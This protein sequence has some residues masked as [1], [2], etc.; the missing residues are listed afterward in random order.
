V[1]AEVLYD[2]RRPRGRRGRGRSWLMGNTVAGCS[3]E[4]DGFPLP[5]ERLHAQ[6]VSLWSLPRRLPRTT[7]TLGRDACTSRTH[8]LIPGW[9]VHHGTT[10]HP[11]PSHGAMPG[12]TVRDGCPCGSI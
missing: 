3:Q 1:D 7:M 2:W 11:A 8:V 6:W 9:S 12:E 10:D 4:G 5:S